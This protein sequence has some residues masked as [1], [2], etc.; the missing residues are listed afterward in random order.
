MNSTVPSTTV[1]SIIASMVNARRGIQSIGQPILF[2]LGSIG[3][4]LNILIFLRHSMRSNSCAIYF[5]GSSWANLSTLTWGM[6]VVILNTF[7]ISSSLGYNTVYCKIRYFIFTS[8][9]LSARACVVLACLDRFLLCSQSVRQRSFCRSSVAIKLLLSAISFCVCISICLLIVYETN[10]TTHVC[11][12]S[13]SEGKILD[14]TIL[15]V[16]NFGIPTILMSTL[17]GL[18]LWRLKQNSRRI[19]RQRVSISC[20]TNLLF[21]D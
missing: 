18:L 4:L 1:D 19:S 14:T 21:L 10:F 16:F 13:T 12:T 11:T 20:E 17:T 3:C 9:Q 15:F 2:A 7:G 5:H 6:L 8:S